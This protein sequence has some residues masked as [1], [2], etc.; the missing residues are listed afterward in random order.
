MSNS[1]FSNFL[2]KKKDKKI[3]RFPLFNISNH[4]FTTCSMKFPTKTSTILK[5]EI[6][7]AQTIR[8]PANYYH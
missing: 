3:G 8:L 7:T 1:L 2:P 4:Q 6:S 5:S